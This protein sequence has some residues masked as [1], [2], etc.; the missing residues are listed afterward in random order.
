MMGN[1]TGFNLIDEPWIVVLGHDGRERNES[2]LG[3]FEHAADFTAI[4]GEVPTQAFAITRLLLAFLH[5]ALDGPADQDAWETLWAATALPM[6]A[7]CSYA[8]RVR[9]RFDL[10][11]P[12]APFFQV[13]GLRT[14]K[15]DVFSLDR[16]V[17]DVPNGEPLF[18]T[19]SGANLARIA[20]A[21]AARWLVHAH[22]FDPSGIKS[23]ALGDDTVKGGKGYPIGPGWSGQIGGVLPQGDDLRQTLVLNLVAR[24]VDTYVRIG[25][26]E[27]L[28]PWER[29]PDQATWQ[30]RPARGAIDLYTWQ[31]R[32]VRLAGG[33][34]GVTGV[35]LAN[36]DKIVPH[37]RHRHEP[38]TAWRYSQP[39]STKLK[40]TVYM[41]LTHVPSR[42]VWRGI[43]AL[44]PAVSGRANAAG[45]EPQPLLVPGVLQW[46]SDLAAQGLLPEAYRPGIRVCGIEYGPQQAT[47]ADIVDDVLPV[48]IIVLRADQPEA[49]KAAENAVTDAEHVAAAI[50]RLAENIAQAAGAEP[51]SGAGDSAQERLYAALEQPY[52][53]WLGALLPG[54][55]IDQARA[56]WQRTLNEHTKPIVA[57]LIS[58][59]S[60]SAWVGRQ[61]RGHWVNV[62]QAEAWFTAALQRALPL[63]QHRLPTT[64]PQEAAR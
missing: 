50:W 44:L 42:S 8:E 56:Q 47:V 27:D 46:I 18:T 13:A 58:A 15:D 24:D 21:E 23:G 63:A 11:D 20:P 43:A 6:Q 3:V 35:V 49:G 54:V 4:G 33:R 29:D 39:Q 14:A 12:V 5:R 19:R 28:P 38:H 53:R 17:A 30:E 37:N 60:P 52:R 36:G 48:S 16:I 34:D 7:I 41:P 45:G 51:K 64:T 10:F 59:A 55:D 22:A 1:D 25:G 40:T 57:E 32:R 62:A 26:H 2:I 61:V 31:T 9:P